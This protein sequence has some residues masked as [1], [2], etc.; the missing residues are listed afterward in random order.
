MPE[1]VLGKIRGTRKIYLRHIE[2]SSNEV[3]DIVETF[4][5]DNNIDTF[6]CL[7]TLRT[8]ILNKIDKIKGLDEQLLSQLSEKD[9]EKELDQILTREDKCLHAYLK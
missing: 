7:N 9:S 2:N 5:P 8:S 6:I 1:E 4:V 3:N